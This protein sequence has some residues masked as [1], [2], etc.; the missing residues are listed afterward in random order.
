MLPFDY[1]RR[2]KGRRSIA[3]SIHTHV[4]SILRAIRALRTHA[5]CCSV[6]RCDCVHHPGRRVLGG[7]VRGDV[8]SDP[9]PPCSCAR[10]AIACWSRGGRCCASLS[11]QHNLATELFQLLLQC[12]CFFLEHARLDH[13]G[14][15]LH[16]FLG[17]F[18]S[19]IGDGSDFFDDLDLVGGLVGLQPDVEGALLFLGLFFGRFAGPSA[20]HARHPS[21]HGTAESHHRRRVVELELLLQ[22][23][24]QVRRLQQREPRDLVRQLRHAW[25]GTVVEHLVPRR[26][27]ERPRQPPRT[28]A[29]ARA[30]GH[31]RP[32]A[33]SSSVPQ[34]LA[35]LGFPTRF[36]PIKRPGLKN[37]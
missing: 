4:E 13:R 28:R 12:F 14:R 10:V 37:R 30:K 15:L 7:R 26:R 11:F 21:H 16:E 18:Q 1:A 3:P 5:S 20:G 17:F 8:C 9:C 27:A 22:Q 33:S 34:T 2:E 29:K 24:G 6:Q 23:L 31:R 19:Q 25:R 32:P 36:L 35:F